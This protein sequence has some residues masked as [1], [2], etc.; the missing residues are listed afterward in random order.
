MIL[1]RK[2]KCNFINKIAKI[3]FHIYN[4]IYKKNKWGGWGAID[5]SPT[6]APFMHTTPLLLISIFPPA[7]LHRWAMFFSSSCHHGRMGRLE[8]DNYLDDD[9]DK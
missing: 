4:N 2:Q 8:S 9:P 7:I 5:P 1:L 6:I 3:S